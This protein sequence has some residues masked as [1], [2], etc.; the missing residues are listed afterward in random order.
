MIRHGWLLCWS[1]VAQMLVRSVP[2]D[3]F[4]AVLIGSHPDS[5]VDR[6]DK[7][8]AVSNLPGLVDLDDRLPD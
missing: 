4:F 5:I 7:K 2:Q 1:D 8:L 6:A 3:G